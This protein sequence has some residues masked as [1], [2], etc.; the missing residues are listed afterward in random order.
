MILSGKGSVKAEPVE[1]KHAPPATFKDL[2]ILT[3]TS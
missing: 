3:A 1:V 2:V